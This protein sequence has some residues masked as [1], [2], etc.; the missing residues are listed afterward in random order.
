MTELQQ[1]KYQDLQAGLPSELSMQLAEVSLALGSAEDQVTSL[2][3]VYSLLNVVLCC[4]VYKLVFSRIII[5]LYGLCIVL[6]TIAYILNNQ[7][8][9]CYINVLYTVC[10]SGKLAPTCM[11]STVWSGV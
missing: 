2:G 1:S 11:S 7:T 6:S 3:T 4:V 8:I 9:F 5:K 10:S